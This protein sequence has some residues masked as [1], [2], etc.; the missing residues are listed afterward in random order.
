MKH[1]IWIAAIL[2]LII[3]SIGPLAAASFAESKLTFLEVLPLGVSSEKIMVTPNV[4]WGSWRGWTASS[5]VELG[6][7]DVVWFNN[8]VANFRSTSF[9]GARVELGV[10]ENGTSF[11]KLG[12]TFNFKRVPG[13]KVVRISPLVVSG[14]PSYD[15]E[16][17]VVWASQ[18]INFRFGSRSL[19]LYSEG[20]MRIE[21]NRG[22]HSYG[23]PALWLTSEGSSFDYGVEAEVFGTKRIIRFG[24]RKRF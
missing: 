10:M 20:F 18:P 1:R 7:D 23:Q 11:T 17:L 13:F 4:S 2:L 3:A 19:A 5:F 6:G 12:P 14:T 24:V 9:L 21:R 22:G 15:Q 8:N 16:L